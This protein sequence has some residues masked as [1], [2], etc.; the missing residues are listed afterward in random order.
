MG[1]LA[2]LVQAEHAGAA[3]DRVRVAEQAVDRIGGGSAVL[4]REQ[5]GAH[6]VEPLVRL[7]AEDAEE[8]GFGLAH[9]AFSRV[10]KR[11][12][13]S[14]TPTSEPSISVALES[15][16]DSVSWSASGSS[17]TSVTS[18]TAKPARVPAALG[19]EHPLRR[20]AARQPEHGGEV[21]DGEQIAAQVAHP[22]RCARGTRRDRELADLADLE[23]V[24]HR[25]RVQLGT[26]PHLHM[27][28]A[29]AAPQH[30]GLAL[31]SRSPP[32]GEGLLELRDQLLERSGGVFA[33]GLVGGELAGGFAD[34]DHGLGDLIGSR[35]LLLGRQDRLLQH[36][37]RGAHQLAHL[38]RLTS[39][40]L[41]RHDRRV[42]LVLDPT[43][44]L[45]DRIG[46]LDRTLRQLAHLARDDRKAATRLTR[47]RGLDRSIQRQQIRL[48]GDLV[49]QLEDLADLLRALTQRQRALRDRVDLLLHVAHRVARLLGGVGHHARVVGDRAAP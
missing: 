6:R 37:G 13:T 33:L 40:L 25:Q 18:S 36:R 14:I 29:H 10:S 38:A 45:P 20:L 44:D 7:V 12:S 39:T 4:D 47:T 31:G 21:E 17:S 5:R 11:R 8:L 2:D 27:D 28:G 19:H 35:A 43:D 3:L 32:P 22:E 15:R 30:G 49:D 9:A 16:S 34:L 42:G 46:R 26:D 1:E 48:L 41:G 23:H 24:R